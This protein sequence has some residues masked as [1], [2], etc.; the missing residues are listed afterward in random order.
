MHSLCLVLQF[1]IFGI[2]VLIL[3]IINLFRKFYKLVSIIDT[4]MESKEDLVLELFF[5]YPTKEWHFEEILKEAKITRSKA[6]LW[7]KK[8]VK[9]GLIA[10][11]KSRG[12]MPFYL[13][14]HE[15]SAYRNRKKLF[16][17][18]NFYK[19]GFLDSL[20]SLPKAKTVILFGSFAR[21][22][23]HK[24][25]DIDIFIYG[26]AEGLNLHN[27]ES[28][29]HKEIQLFECPDNKKLKE[30]GDALIRN[31]IK[32]NVIKGNIDFVKVSI[33]A[34]VS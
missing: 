27:F 14:N 16:A 8:F 7:L 30:M 6:N 31:I 2:A 26:N 11:I 32:G 1:F 15:S 34:K 21:S 22:D 12:R 24:G 18:E 23:W 29:L 9:E 25:S 13:A 33:N 19:T 20:S 4:I 5:E 10:R 17:M 3:L 28:K